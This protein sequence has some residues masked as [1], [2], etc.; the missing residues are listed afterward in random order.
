MLSDHAEPSQAAS[1]ETFKGLCV[2][3]LGG[4]GRVQGDRRGQ[5]SQFLKGKK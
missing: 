5:R 3:G 4:G 2:I 1:C